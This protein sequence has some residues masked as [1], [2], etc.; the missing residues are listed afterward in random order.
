MG[1]E[2][3]RVP[4]N[5]DWPLNQRW[6]GF[7]TPD[8]LKGKPCPDCDSGQTAAGWWLATYCY[9]LGMVAADLLDQ[10]SGKAMHP[11]LADDPYPAHGNGTTVLRPGRD[12]LDLLTGLT[13]MS[14]HEVL[15]FG[16]SSSV[17]WR[18]YRKISEAAGLPDFG[19]CRTCDGEGDL[20][21]YPGQRAEREAWKPTDPPAGE[22]WQLW[23]TV[24]EGSPISPVFGSAEQLAAWMASPAYRWGAADGA[25]ITYEQALR[26]VHAGWAPTLLDTGDGRGPVPGEQAV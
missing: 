13:G 12:I 17:Q 23:E 6:E 5:F 14:E 18:L 16:G 1:R 8:R 15:S 11:W 19:V 9:R 10:R 4:L 20:E 22:G 21:T 25:S 24:S 2:V 3:R 7:L 26:F